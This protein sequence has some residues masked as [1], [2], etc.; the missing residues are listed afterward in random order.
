MVDVDRGDRRQGPPRPYR[1]QA[2]AEAVEATTERIRRAAHR[3]FAEQPYD[4]VTLNQVGAHAQ[5][6]MQTVLRRFDSKESL[7]AAVVR[8]RSSQIRGERDQPPG[9]DPAV[10][11]ASLVDS[12]ERWGP[13]I[14]HLL[15]QETRSPVIAE[16]IE[17]GR[18][19]HHQWVRRVFSARLGHLSPADRRRQLEKLIAVTDLYTW[20]VLR[21]DQ[22]LSRRR[23]E[24][25]ILELVECSLR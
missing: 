25:A 23:V 2:R 18:S 21:H 6:T 17:S 10:A 24:R 8:W 22:R 20:K 9:D 14:L 5:V 19:F 4:Q 13:E 7:F 12:Y 1:M 15:G 16:A 11:V 3:L